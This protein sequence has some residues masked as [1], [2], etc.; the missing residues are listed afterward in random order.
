MKR[1][2]DYWFFAVFAV[3]ASVSLLARL[4]HLFAKK[5]LVEL[6]VLQLLRPTEILN[7]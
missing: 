1:R 4:E 7:C 3:V 2:V 6:V 5:L